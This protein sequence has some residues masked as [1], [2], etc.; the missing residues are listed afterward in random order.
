MSLND[1]DRYA[2]LD[3]SAEVDARLTDSR[4]LVLLPTRD[5]AT[6]TP[7]GLERSA[8]NVVN[9]NF[10]RYCVFTSCHAFSGRCEY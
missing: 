4:L 9:A 10:D 7:G 2:T 6:M 3:E 1:M 8:E 5:A